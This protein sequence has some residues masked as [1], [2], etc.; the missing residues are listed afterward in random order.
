MDFGIKDP[1][2]KRSPD[3]PSID[4]AMADKTRGYK[5]VLE[6]AKCAIQKQSASLAVQTANTTECEKRPLSFP[7]LSDQ[8]R[9]KEGLSTGI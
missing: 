1:T 9:H 4:K 6:A 7:D 5:D 3:Q 8:K 2:E